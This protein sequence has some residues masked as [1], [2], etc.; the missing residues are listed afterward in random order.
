MVAILQYCILGP[1]S[2][3]LYTPNQENIFYC[4]C[5][6]YNSVIMMSLAQ[7]FFPGSELVCPTGPFTSSHGCPQVQKIYCIPN[8][9]CKH[10]SKAVPPSTLPVLKNT[11]QSNKLLKLESE[12]SYLTPLSPSPSTSDD[13]LS[14]IWF[15]LHSIF[16]LCPL[17]STCSTTVLIWPSHIS[18]L[19]QC[20]AT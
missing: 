12:T 19:C 14:L 8:W 17:S 9:I 16:P 5:F 10:F 3:L 20:H 7:I 11:T 6:K 4:T 13:W 1:N 15:F 18:C 2:S